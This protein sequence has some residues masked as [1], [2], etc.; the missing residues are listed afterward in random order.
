MSLNL[1]GWDMEDVHERMK[2][3]TLFEVISIYREIET[4]TVQKSLEYMQSV[5]DNNESAKERC[6]NAIDHLQKEKCVVAIH[7]A[8]ELSG[9][10][11]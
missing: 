6:E 11:Q 2:G 3:K 8:N 5:R 1:N 10:G 9:I 4:L 7:I